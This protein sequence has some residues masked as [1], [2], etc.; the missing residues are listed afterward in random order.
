MRDAGFVGLAVTLTLLAGFA[1]A[2][3]QDLAFKRGWRYRELRRPGGVAVLIGAAVTAAVTG[4]VLGNLFIGVAAIVAG[5][6]SLTILRRHGRALSFG[7]L[8]TAATV[9]VVAL[10]A[11]LVAFGLPVADV[12]FTA[13]LLATFCSLL[14]E[15]DALGWYGWGIALASAAAITAMSYW[16]D[17]TDDARMALL[18]TGAVFGVISVAPFRSGMLG[19]TGARFVGLVIGG[20][21]IRATDGSPSAAYGV[22]VVALVITA[23]WVTSLPSPDRKRLLLSFGGVGVLFGVVSVPAALALI[24]TYKP[25]TRTV[26][27]SRGLV[28]ADPRGGL[29]TAGAR[30]APV[31]KQFE[32]YANRFESP[33]V[34]V[35]RFVPFVGANVRAT[36]VAARSAAN[37][38]ASAR[39]ILDRANVRA[40]SPRG[41]VVDRQ[42]LRNLHGGLRTVQDV[43]GESRNNLRAGGNFDL[44]VPPL[45]RG[46]NDLL[47]QLTAVKQRVDVSVRGTLVAED[48]LGY[49]KPRRFFV[50]MQNNAESRATGGYI[51]NYGIVTMQNGGVVSREFKRTSDFDDAGDK[52]R[53]LNASLDFRRRYSRF[54]VESNWTN[55]NLSPDYPTIAALIADQYEQ[56][57]DES[58]DGVFTLDPVGLAALLKLTGPVRV[59]SWPVP[60]TDRNVAAIV[61]HDEYILFENNQAARL[62]FLGDVGE[63]VFDKLIAGGLGDL[64][65]AAPVIEGMIEGRRL[66][67]WSGDREAAAFFAETGSGGA[68]SE[69][70]GDSLIVTTQNA[71]ANKADFFQKR[72]IKYEATVARRGNGLAVD[73]RATVRLMNGAP[74]SGQPRYVI[75]PNETD[76]QPGQ[77]RVFATVYSP[78]DVTRATLDGEPIRLDFAPELGLNAYS[79]F[80][81]IPAGGTRTIDLRLKG[82]LPNVI[83]YTLDVF[84]QPMVTPDSL[85]IAVTGAGRVRKFRSL[86]PLLSDVRLDL[87]VR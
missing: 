38:A 79:L 52:P 87:P 26:A 40:V 27:E 3:F 78:F 30:L 15:T 82:R 32:G 46:V 4:L 7:I 1:I 5:L 37:L 58:V 12:V 55:V 35:A 85:E 16:L 19:R 47:S 66:Q 76:L 20:M 84:Q 69:T 33:T 42:A 68:V 74:S 63:A 2:A 29:E 9:L 28:R 65:A 59:P 64:L 39:L 31:Q 86:G 14:R 23:L 53:R 67:L 72:V 8:W 11:K 60:L 10:D 18:I 62:D 44:L 43:V 49:E 34:A 71:A 57:S 77:N 80:L 51:A 13:F 75:G 6:S 25:M 17:R 54:D 83:R 56:F 48:M 50:A 21:A 73:A 45:R 24:D 70:K 81:D 41:G 61:L 22:V 36:A